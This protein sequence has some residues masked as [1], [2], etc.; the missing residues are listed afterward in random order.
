M[1]NECRVDVD[2]KGA[3][4]GDPGAVKHSNSHPSDLRTDSWVLN[5]P[6]DINPPPSVPLQ[7]G[8]TSSIFRR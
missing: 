5:I 3:D 7:Q 2:N 4:E 8:K 6:P 1:V